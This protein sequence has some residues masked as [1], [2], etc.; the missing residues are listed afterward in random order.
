MKILK[1]IEGKIKHPIKQLIAMLQNIMSVKGKNNLVILAGKKLKLYQFVHTKIVGDNNFIEFFGNISKMKNIFISIEG[2]SNHIKIDKT[3][4]SIHDLHINI[5]GDGNSLNIGE[6]FSCGETTFTIYNGST[7]NIGD[8]CMFASNILI[9]TTDRHYI[10]DSSNHII[11]L[12]KDVNIGKHVWVCAGCNILKGSY[13]DDDCVLGNS[14]VLT[15]NYKGNPNCII[16]GNPAK[17][18]KEDINWKR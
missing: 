14:S 13:I 8:D 11:N 16:V 10:Y 2:N 9:W 7:V 6:N 5:R 12:E 15:K 18:V 4:N 1:S 3:N 17:I